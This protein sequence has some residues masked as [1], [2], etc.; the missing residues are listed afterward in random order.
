MISDFVRDKDAIA[1]CAMLAE[2]TAWAKDQGLSV[3]DLLAEI[4]QQYGFYLEK[5]VSMTKKGMQGAAEIKQMMVDL[6]ETPPAA[7]AGSPVVKTIDYLSSIE[8]N[9]VTGE[10]KPVNLLKSN[11]LQF[12]LEDGSKISARPSGTEPK[13][14][15]YVSVNKPL[16]DKANYNAVKAEL[17]ARIEAIK[18]DFNI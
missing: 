7:I 2:M 8:K 14:K 1:S 6:R 15:F 18:T 5:L 10:E 9:V 11:V 13:I 17:E 16:D 4:Y 3:F 12:F